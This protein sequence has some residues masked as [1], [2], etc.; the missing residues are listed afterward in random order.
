MR[1]IQLYKN[2]FSGFTREVYYLACVIFINRMGTMVLPFLSVYLVS[3]LNLSITEAGYILV[4]YG[5]GAVNGSFVG[6]WLVDRLGAIRVQI[7]SLTLGG[8]GLISL[9][10]VSQYNTFIIIILLTSFSAEMIRPSNAAAFIFFSRPENRTRA[11]A[12]NR[13]AINLGMAIGPA[14]GGFFATKSYTLL[15]IFDGATCLVAACAT[16]YL[17][18]N[19]IG[20]EKHEAKN[21]Q[22]RKKKS[23]GYQIKPFLIFLSIAFLIAFMFFQFFGTYPLYIKTV[24]QLTELQIGL[25][26]TINGFIIVIFEMLIAHYSE[27][28][29]QIKFLQLGTFLIGFSFFLLPFGQSFL[30]AA[31]LMVLLTFGEILTLPLLGNIVS[32]VVDP[33]R[34]GKMMG[35]YTSIFGISH[36]VAPFIGTQIYERFSPSALWTTIFAI[37]LPIFFLSAYFGRLIQAKQ[38]N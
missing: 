17:F 21:D 30:M 38:R 13:L 11:F 26:F 2:A 6:G 4:A 22:S 37:V 19:R 24:Y 3:K 8:I 10:M 29:N 16:L 31:M 28:R 27:N 5:F 18:K 23:D 20:E 25:L 12:M 33:N 9:S 7:L 1:I 35:M 15:F 34:I 14:L 32:K 36:I